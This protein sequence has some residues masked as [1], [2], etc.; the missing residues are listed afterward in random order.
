MVTRASRPGSPPDQSAQVG[1]ESHIE[2]AVGLVDHEDA[3]LAQIKLVLVGEIE[4]PAGR[5]DCHPHAIRQRPF[6]IRIAHAAVE[7]GDGKVEILAELAR[8]VFDLVS[9]L[10][11]RRDDQGDAVVEAAL[12][13][14][15]LK[16]ADEKGG[17]LAGAGLRL[18]RN[19]GADETVDEGL[20]LYRRTLGESQIVSRLEDLRIK[21]KLVEMSYERLQIDG[22][23]G[24]RESRAKR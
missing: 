11:G 12:L 21:I 20:L 10:A 4:Q 7:T 13:Q 17:G 15:Q 19:V 1:Y 5:T 9:K 6:L 3:H 18:D 24:P 14:K 23:A 22:V 2:Q 16:D 8:I